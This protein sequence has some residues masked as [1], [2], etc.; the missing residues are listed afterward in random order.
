MRKKIETE[1][2]GYLHGDSDRPRLRR[3]ALLRRQN[4]AIIFARGPCGPQM[5]GQRAAVAPQ[6]QRGWGK[7][8]QIMHRSRQM[9]NVIH[10]TR[11]NTVGC[12]PITHHP[13]VRPKAPRP[14]YQYP[15]T[16]DRIRHRSYLSFTTSTGGY[17][18]INDSFQTASMICN[19]ES[20]SRRRVR[21]VL[22]R[23]AWVTIAILAFAGCL[24]FASVVRAQVQESTKGMTCEELCT[25]KKKVCEYQGSSPELCKYDY[26]ECIKACSEKK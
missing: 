15:R 3:P 26:N 20:I 9:D 23:A 19:G 14:A 8:I 18:V 17:T 12:S 11:V 2:H 1:H 13:P 16:A 6:T 22:A 10:G 4:C 25:H 7:I 24:N 21:L 5:S